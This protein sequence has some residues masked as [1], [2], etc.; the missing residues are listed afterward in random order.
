MSKTQSSRL[1]GVV[2]AAV[3]VLT[4]ACTVPREQSVLDEFFGASRLRDLTAL[5]RI[6]LVVLE[7]REG[8]TVGQFTIRSV[9]GIERVP[10]RGDDP[11]V[12]RSLLALHDAAA[13]ALRRCRDR[14]TC[15]SHGAPRYRSGP[16]AL[17]SGCSTSSAGEPSR[18]RR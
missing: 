2:V 16:P 1:R 5:A 13:R 9:S 12:E 7:P 14:M 17:M 15:L 6:S 4:L 11:V 10:L 18:C 8:G 3:Q